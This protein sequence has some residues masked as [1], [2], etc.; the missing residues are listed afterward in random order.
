VNLG[1]PFFSNCTTYERKTGF[2]LIE[3][4]SK[5]F[6]TQTMVTRIY[7]LV[8]VFLYVR[9]S[10][11]HIKHATSS[12]QNNVRGFLITFSSLSLN[13]IYPK[14]PFL[15]VSISGISFKSVQSCKHKQ[16]KMLNRDNYFFRLYSAPRNIP[17]LK[18]SHH[19]EDD[20]YVE[21]Q[22]GS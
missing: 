1:R 21:I 19:K 8:A 3:V 22:F 13:A 12:R 17:C 2:L 18:I 7:L 16:S 6:N 9:V 11:K 4:F 20:R 10:S 14:K 15:T 5:L